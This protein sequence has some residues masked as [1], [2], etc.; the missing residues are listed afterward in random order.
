M[1]VPNSNFKEYLVLMCLASHFDT[2]E[3]WKIIIWYSDFYY[4]RKY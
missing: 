1:S 3:S 2:I 4:A